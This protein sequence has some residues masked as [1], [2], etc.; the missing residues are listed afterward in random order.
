MKMTTINHNP[1][2]LRENLIMMALYI[3]FIDLCSLVDEVDG[4]CELMSTKYYLSGQA[5]GWR[6]ASSY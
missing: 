2:S 1:W 4:K 6:V 3:Y 5:Y